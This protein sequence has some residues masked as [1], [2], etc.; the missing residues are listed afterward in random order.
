MYSGGQLK[1]DRYMMSIM[2]TVP[3]QQT[4][5]VR[6]NVSATEITVNQDLTFAKKRT[7]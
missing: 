1:L 4:L 5:T 3:Y 7:A 6:I 2:T